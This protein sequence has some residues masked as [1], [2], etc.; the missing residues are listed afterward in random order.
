MNYFA[1][2]NSCRGIQELLEKR[3]IV[4]DAIPPYMG[5]HYPDSQP[6]EINFKLET[7]VDRHKY[8]ELFLR[9]DNQLRVGQS[10]P[11]SF[12]NSYDFMIGKR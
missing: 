12:S 6:R 4:V 8:I 9:L 10:S 5:Y 7:L 3:L 11:L 2:S 1:R